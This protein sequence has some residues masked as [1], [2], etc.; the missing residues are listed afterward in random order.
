MAVRID[1]DLDADAMYVTL[2]DGMAAKTQEV[3]DL[4]FVDVD[5]EGHLLGIEVVGL[6]RAWPLEEIISRFDVP[7]FDAKQLRAQF[8]GVRGAEGRREVPKLSVDCV[9]AS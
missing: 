3:E 7:E 2:A 4:T 5:E 6:A 8:A 1:Y 9:A